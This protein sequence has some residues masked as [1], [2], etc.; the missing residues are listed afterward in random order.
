MSDP[1]RK[2][3]RLALLD[4]YAGEP[5]LG[6]GRLREITAALGEVLHVDEFDVRSKGELPDLSYDIYLSSG[7]PGSPLPVG[8]DWEQRWYELAGQVWQHNATRPDRPKF[9][10]FIC[11]SFQ[12]AC[13]HF[14][15]GEVRKRRAKSFGTFPVYKT[16]DGRRDPLLEGLPD[17]FWVA[18]FREYQVVDVQAEQLARSG[19]RLL[20]IE[21][22]RLESHLPRA[23][24]A[25]RFSEEMV[26]VQFHPEAD[27][28]G[29]L[30]HF[31][32]E[33]RKQAIIEEY[34]AERYYEMLAHLADP[35]K[36]ELTHRI[37]LPGFLERSLH[38]L[39]VSLPEKA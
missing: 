20:A 37:V 14:G 25:V 35:D 28:A 15:L 1:T 2:S 21:Q 3:A 10:F 8:E 26:G 9:F 12:M 30:Q 22:P 5:N 36:I 34:G 18:D 33:E 24:M 31:S 13:I 11:H 6:M 39:G 32:Q 7:G 17:P 29:M 23:I 38:R 16:P 19:A 4:M 27:S